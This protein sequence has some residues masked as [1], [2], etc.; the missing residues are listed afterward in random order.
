MQ[1]ISLS[2]QGV[3]ADDLLQVNI[4]INFKDMVAT[5]RH[6]LSLVL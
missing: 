4:H 5:G 1:V 6:G 2:V 3:T